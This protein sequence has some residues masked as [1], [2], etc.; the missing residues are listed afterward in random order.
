MSKKEDKIIII[1]KFK[2][3]EAVNVKTLLE[4]SFKMYYNM[5]LTKKVG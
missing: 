2:E 5:Q 3:N 1:N 4:N